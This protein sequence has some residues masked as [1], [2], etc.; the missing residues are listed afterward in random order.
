M[1]IP[2]HPRWFFMLA[3]AVL[4][5][6]MFM[7]AN[8]QKKKKDTPAPASPTEQRSP[9]HYSGSLRELLVSLQ[10]QATNL[11]HLTKV[12]SDYVVFE[13]EGDTLMF[14]IS[15]LQSVKFAK[16]EEGESRKIEIRFQ[17][18]D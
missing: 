8:A 14:P 7:P 12:A 2:S 18:R 13:N 1:P 3:A 17:A 9:Q 15:V 16:A 10:G 6:C 11:G 4:L 5:A